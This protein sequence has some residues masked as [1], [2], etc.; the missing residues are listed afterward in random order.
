MEMEGTGL[1]GKRSET[2]DFSAYVTTADLAV[3]TYTLK[4]IYAKSVF[5]I[6]NTWTAKQKDSNELEDTVTVEKTFTVKATSTGENADN[7]KDSGNL[8]S[9][10]T[11]DNGNI[12][13]LV[14][15]LL[16]SGIG[17]FIAKRRK[18]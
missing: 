6:D 1:S 4:V 3:G 17:I 16:I 15:D 9:P 7:V 18:I 11:G 5:D 13:L 8:V 12:W 2:E 14:A 10:K